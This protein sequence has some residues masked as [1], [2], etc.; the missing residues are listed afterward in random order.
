MPEPSKVRRPQQQR[1]IEKKERILTAGGALFS[2]KGYYQATTPE[3][4]ARAGVST[5]AL[6][7]YFT[8]KHMILME[9]FT[10][11]TQEFDGLIDS[12]DNR[13]QEQR[14]N[15]K[16]IFESFFFHMLDIHNKH[17]ELLLEVESL[18]ASDAE[19]RAQ[20]TARERKIQEYILTLMRHARGHFHVQDEEAAAA[21]LYEFTE[22][23]VDRVAFCE[24]GKKGERIIAEGLRAICLYLQLED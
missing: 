15:L 6:Y 12:M 8:D 11:I 22:A 5:G 4:A 20:Y 1:S 10:R 19:I 3:I 13:L 9:L 14:P 18:C 17:R 24:T 16:K 2:E 23:L 21:V 7:S